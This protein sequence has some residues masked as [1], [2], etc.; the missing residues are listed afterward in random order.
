MTMTIS[1]LLLFIALLCTILSAIGKVPLWVAVL[2]LCL[3][4]LLGGRL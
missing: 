3:M 2:C 4:F 1:T